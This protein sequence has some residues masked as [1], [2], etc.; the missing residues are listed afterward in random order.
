MTFEL[1]LTD[2]QAELNAELLRLAN[3]APTRPPAPPSWTGPTP[4]KPPG[5]RRRR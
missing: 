5:P 2:E 3:P 4:R 1:V